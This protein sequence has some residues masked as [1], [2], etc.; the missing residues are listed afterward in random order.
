[1]VAAIHT[2]MTNNTQ[3]QKTE[4][5]TTI[6]VTNLE[7]VTGG[8]MMDSIMPMIQK[9]IGPMISKFMGGAKQGGEG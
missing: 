8:G 4:E 7:H 3:S 5:L 9:F 6:D 1:M 2:G